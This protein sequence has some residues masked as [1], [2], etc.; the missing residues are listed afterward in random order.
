MDD[1]EVCQVGSGVFPS[2]GGAGGLDGV[3]RLADRAVAQGMEVEL[4]VEGVEGGDVAARSAGSMK[5]MPVLSVA[6]P[7]A[8]R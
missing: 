1:L 7:Q 2:V 3:Q 6:Q 8:F 5:L 4:E